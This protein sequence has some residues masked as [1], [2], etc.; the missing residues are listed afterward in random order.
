MGAM[1]TK[2]CCLGYT[3]D[4]TTLLLSG[5]YNK[6][7]K[8]SLWNNQYSRMWKKPHLL[9]TLL[10]SKNAPHLGAVFGW[11]F[12]LMNTCCIR[13]VARANR[14]DWSTCAIGAFAPD[15]GQ[16]GTANCGGAMQQDSLIPCPNVTLQ[17]T[18]RTLDI[19]SASELTN[20]LPRPS[21]NS[22]KP[23]SLNRL[24]IR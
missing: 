22:T 17:R 24:H 13:G 4:Y 15:L 1:K 21:S 20:L 8:G 11:M 7:L 2:T 12:D 18:Q 5:E 14:R 3:R 10:T 23:E 6:T 9:L 19:S 16:D